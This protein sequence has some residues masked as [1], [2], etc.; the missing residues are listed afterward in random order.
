MRIDLI[1]GLTKGPQG[2]ELERSH[3][4]TWGKHIEE[5]FAGKD[6]EGFVEKTGILWKYAFVPATIFTIYD[7][8][9]YNRHGGI[10]NVL[11]RMRFHYVPWFGCCIAYTSTVHVVSAFRGKTDQWNH[12]IGG[13]AVGTCIGKFSRNFRIGL[14]NGLGFALLCYY[15]KDS[16]MN[17]YEVFPT[18]GNPRLG[19]PWTHKNDYTTDW[20]APRPGY[21]ARSQDDVEKVFKQGQLG[22]GNYHKKLW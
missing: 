17:G 19:N 12:F 6:D 15:Y 1:T 5:A 10:P 21:W 3:D 18:V 16:K 20:F 4:D 8:N 7:V 2:P 9:C 22:D 13:F 11:K 14:A